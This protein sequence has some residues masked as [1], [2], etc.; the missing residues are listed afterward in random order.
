MTHLLND[1]RF[2]LRLLLSRPVV[3]A[4]AA[5]SL[6]LGI[7]ANTAIFSLVN[8]VFLAPLPVER[9]HELVAVFTTV[10]QNQ[11]GAFG[12]TM[13]TSRMNYED[14]RARTT[15]FSDLAAAAFT[16][17]SISSGAGEPEQVP[18]QLVSGN[19]FRTLGPPMALG[20]GF[21]PEEDAAPGAGPVAVLSYG[22]WQRRFGGDAGIVG[23]TVTVNGLPLTVVGVTAESY[24][25]IGIF[26]APGLWVPFSMH[27]E[28]A[29]GFLAEN[30]DSRRALLMQIIGRLKPG[31]GVEA[32]AANVRAVGD[33]LAQDFPVDNRG[34]TGLAVPLAD[35]T[36][37]P[38]P[39]QRQ[40]ITTAGALLT[41][42]VALVLLIACA[43][44]ANLLLALA[45]TR[46][47]EV[48]VR[49]SIG[50]GRSQL[51]RQLLVESTML[52]LL[53]GVVGLLVAYWARLGL[54]AMR[55]PFL[56][57]GAL[58]MDLDGRVLAFTAVVAVLTGLVFGLAPALQL[59]KP[60][61]VAE[62]KDRSSQAS[63]SR[64]WFSLKNALVVTQVALSCVA[65][66]GAGLF[67]RSLGNARRIDPGFDVASLATLSFNLAARGLAGEA[68]QARQAEVLDRVRGLPGVR[69]AALSN[70]L[71]LGGGGFLRSIFLEGQDATDQRAGRFA[72]IAVVSDSYF[73]TTGIRLLRGRT[74]TPADTM[75]APRV[76]VVNQ[77]MAERFWPGEDAIGRRFRFFGDTD[78]TEVVGVAR[79]GK[80]NFIG[81]DPQAFLYQPLTQVVQPQVSLIV[82]SD[83]PE[84]TLG[85]V[86]AVVQGMEPTLP[87]TGVNTMATV[88]DQGL[89]AARMGALLLGVFGAL[90]LVL[91]AIGV[92]GIMAHAVGQRTR[93]IGVRLALGA[94]AGDVWR[95]VLRQGLVLTVAGILVGAG[96]AA[97][98]ASSLTA[99]L[100][101]V[102]TFDP[103]TFGS[104]ALMLL[105]VAVVAIGIPAYRASR[106]DA[107]VALRAN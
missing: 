6:G 27:R 42:V 26:G 102:S 84:A 40:A 20:R 56:P 3:T 28:M 12:G 62:L 76:V 54:L 101:G 88:L 95:M 105:A 64:G 85:A 73:E 58:T 55:P 68:A 11:Q 31:V 5:L 77:T 44:V 17:L 99:L 74:F 16:P 25:G 72:Q 10:P 4:A 63:A 66:V 90:A 53:G 7:G 29:A 33:A 75:T 46:R 18:G 43:N 34:R 39:A 57:D 32:A 82:R 93:E 104:I 49:L 78:Y 96:L 23:R 24:T 19:Y 14:Y 83:T 35:T 106:V 1:I 22:L 59:S 2:A 13:P 81:E 71:P 69:H 70:N 8:E 41:V 36:I 98:G 45:T 9:P 15:V 61:L 79:D 87:L 94:T 100:Y 67:L 89:W 80:Y 30:W 91:A 21:V 38:V 97:A 60:D 50:A 86:R 51:I 52:G 92:Y 48:A 47:H 65:L 37:S 107:T 103:L